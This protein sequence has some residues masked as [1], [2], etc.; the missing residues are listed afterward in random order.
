[1]NGNRWAGHTGCMTSFTEKKKRKKKV[2]FCLFGCVFFLIKLQPLFPKHTLQNL[3][4]IFFLS[5]K[6]LFPIPVEQ[7]CS[8]LLQRD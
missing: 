4:V 3:D 2:F 7:S 6:P 1:M 8:A 5:P